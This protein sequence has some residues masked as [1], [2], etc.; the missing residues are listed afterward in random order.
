M[1]P[2]CSQWSFILFSSRTQVSNVFPIQHTLSHILHTKFHSCNPIQNS[3]KEKTTINYDH[4]VFCD[5]SA[6]QMHPF[7]NKFELGGP[8]KYLI[9]I[10]AHTMFRSKF[11]RKFVAMSRIN[12]FC[13][14]KIWLLLQL[15]LQLI[16]RLSGSPGDWFQILITKWKLEKKWQTAELRWQQRRTQLGAPHVPINNFHPSSKLYAEGDD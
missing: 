4:S 11:V 13:K 2:Q 8:H 9:W 3:P 6:N 12:I 16:G 10:T 14:S 7:R 5:G 1:V 15:L